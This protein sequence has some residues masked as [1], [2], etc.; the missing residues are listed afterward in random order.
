[1]EESQQIFDMLVNI[2]VY[3]G[4]ATTIVTTIVVVVR[5]IIKKVKKWVNE[6]VGTKNQDGQI[7]LLGDKL[8]SIAE[9]LDAHLVKDEIRAEVQMV[10]LKN[11]LLGII[12]ASVEKGYASVEQKKVV[13][14]LYV[15]Y[16]K[17]N[18]N[19]LIDS[20]WATFIKLPDS[21]EMVDKK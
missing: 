4:A 16:K 8:D 14:Q 15:L 7:K 2:S 1:M 18:G 10:Q 5:K 6:Q 3:I 13:E 9:K 20:Y 21:K 17:L 12:T 19:G 11:E